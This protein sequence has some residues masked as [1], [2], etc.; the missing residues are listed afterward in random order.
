MVNRQLKS[1]DYSAFLELQSSNNRLHVITTRNIPKAAIIIH[2]KGKILKH[3]NQFSIQIDY[4]KHL[5]K[6]GMI[7]DEMGHSCKSNAMIEYRDL[8]IRSTRTI[9]PGEK[10]TINYCASEDV[11]ANPFFCD[12]GQKDCY[13]Q[14][15]GYAFLKPKQQKSLRKYLSPFL[16]KKYHIQKHLSGA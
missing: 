13:G 5:G 1:V 3:P 15:R 4:N 14:V 7:D 6:G 2:L 16:R 11:L 9:M 12:C 10:V 8:T